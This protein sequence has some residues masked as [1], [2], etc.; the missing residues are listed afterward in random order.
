MMFVVIFAT[1]PCPA[2]VTRG[3]I[4]AKGRVGIKIFDY[5][6]STDA[7][8]LPILI[9]FGLLFVLPVLLK[10]IYKII[11]PD[12][13]MSYGDAFAIVAMS[14]P[15]ILLLI[16]SVETTIFL[17]SD[18]L[19]ILIGAILFW[20]LVW[21]ALVCYNIWAFKNRRHHHWH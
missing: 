18:N 3:R 6:N 19:Y 20:G 21:Y 2:P 11:R 16:I 7:S 15:Y 17:G 4:A 8:P 13:Y 1:L 14:I 10:L 12:G 5:L 9:G